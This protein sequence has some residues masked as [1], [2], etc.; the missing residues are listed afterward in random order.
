MN[1]AR[2]VGLQWSYNWPADQPHNLSKDQWQT[3]NNLDA[4]TAC[5]YLVSYP[6]KELFCGGNRGEADGLA[7]E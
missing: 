4:P 7:V 3:L 6:D 2:V 1:I 5:V